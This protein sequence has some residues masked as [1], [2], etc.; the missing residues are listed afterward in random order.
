M[1]SVESFYSLDSTDSRW[2]T[3]WFWNAVHFHALFQL[4]D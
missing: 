4:S 2:H 1:D 3:H